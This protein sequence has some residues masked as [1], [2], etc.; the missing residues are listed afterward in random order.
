MLTKC[1]S[2]TKD[3]CTRPRRSRTTLHA[4]SRRPGFVESCAHCQ[5]LLPSCGSCGSFGTRERG[6]QR[7]K[8]VLAKS[9]KGGKRQRWE[10]GQAR[11][12][13]K[14]QWARASRRQPRCFIRNQT[15]H[16]GLQCPSRGKGT[17]LQVGVAGMLVEIPTSSGLPS[18][19]MV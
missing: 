12:K 4:H 1:P 3:N 14:A 10:H 8:K 13:V 11:K 16:L 7:A 18:L 15:G 19:A 17:A 2:Q 5:G 9:W 6:T